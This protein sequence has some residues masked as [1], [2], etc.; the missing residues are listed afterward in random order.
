M[1]R[2]P[3][4][5]TEPTASS[6]WRMAS[7]VEPN[8]PISD[9]ELDVLKQLW[10][11]P[12]G[13]TVRALHES[14]RDAGH[15][16]AYTTVQTLLQRLEEKGYIR[17]DASERAHIFKATTS[18]ENLVGSQLDDLMERL[19]EGEASPLLLSLVQRRSFS[20]QDISE[21]RKLLKQMEHEETPEGEARSGHHDAPPRRRKR[22]SEGDDSRG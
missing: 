22:R 12:D 3:Y 18:R 14:L 20:T 19:C 16:W 2:T 21:L 9:A 11:S 1:C 8:K 6:V 15:D 5:F 7:M 17:K 10:D 13:A 4:N